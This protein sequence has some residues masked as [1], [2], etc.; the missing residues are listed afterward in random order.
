MRNDALANIA[1]PDG[2][3][4]DTSG[5]IGRHRQRAQ[6]DRGSCYCSRQVAAISGPVYQWRI[7]R[8]SAE[9][10]IEIAIGT[11][12]CRQD[13]NLAG[14]GA[15]VSKSIDLFL[16]GVRAA[17]DAQQKRIASIFIGRQIAALKNTPFDVPP[18]I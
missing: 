9:K 3:G 17:D 12:R 18:R 4:Q 1:L 10:I 5:S 7:D 8:D 2:H 6:A 11:G 14:T 13:D 16:I 15:C